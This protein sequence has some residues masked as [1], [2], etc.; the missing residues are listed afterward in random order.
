[1][2]DGV[3]SGFLLREDSVFRASKSIFSQKTLDKPFFPC[4]T[5]NT[6]MRKAKALALPPWGMPCVFHLA[7]YQKTRGAKGGTPSFC[8]FLHFVAWKN[9]SKEEVKD[10]EKSGDKEAD[11]KESENKASDDSE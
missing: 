5:E 3:P 1:M 8:A 4:Y 10:K 11:D 7:V 2:P 6:K 9:K